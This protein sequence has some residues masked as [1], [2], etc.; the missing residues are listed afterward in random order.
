MGLT[1][2]LMAGQQ[3]APVMVGAQGR[4]GHG[5]AHHV[6]GDSR[7]Q[8][9]GGVQ[10]AKDNGLACRVSQHV[11]DAF[12][13]LQRIERHAD[14]PGEHYRQV[15]QQ[16]LRAILGQYRHPVPRLAAQ[17]A[18]GAGQ[19]PGPVIGL[20]PGDGVPGARHRLTQPDAVRT[21]RHP[22]GETLQRQLL[23]HPTALLL[24]LSTRRAMDHHPRA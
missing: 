13:R 20:A 14:Q 11:V 10:L 5:D 9:L 17:R 1:Q 8:A 2:G 4:I 19:A 21:G 7:L 22:M 3:L 23:A 12:R 15:A 18:Q 6:R 24:L 16:P